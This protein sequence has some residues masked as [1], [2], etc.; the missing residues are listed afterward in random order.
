MNERIRLLRKELKLTLEEFGKR[1]GIKK[2]S[3]SLLER[4]INNPS[5]QTVLSICREFNV[6]E[7][8]LREGKGE[9]FFRPTRSSEIARLTKELLSEESDSFKNC[10]FVQVEY[11]AVE[12]I[13]GTCDPAGCKI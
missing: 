11:R 13:G 3:I 8:W 1:I 5:E 10:F 12:S 4:G 2:S 7:E 9:M 6:N